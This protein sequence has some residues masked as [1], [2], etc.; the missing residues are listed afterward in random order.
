MP[1]STSLQ[2]ELVACWPMG[3]QLEELARPRWMSKMRRTRSFEVSPMS[4]PDR[5]F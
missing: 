4:V 1:G 3:I 5:K 2:V